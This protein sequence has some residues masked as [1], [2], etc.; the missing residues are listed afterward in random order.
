MYRLISVTKDLL[1]DTMDP[2]KAAR[3]DRRGVDKTC[4]E[5]T[6]DLLVS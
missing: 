6:V 2:H 4:T 3:T 5:R 1:G